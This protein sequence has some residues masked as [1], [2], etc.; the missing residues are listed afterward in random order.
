MRLVVDSL[1]TGDTTVAQSTQHACRI[2]M[3]DLNAEKSATQPGT[4]THA[5]M[6]SISDMNTAVAM[7]I[8]A[9]GGR[10]PSVDD[11][12]RLEK[13]LNSSSATIERVLDPNQ[14]FVEMPNQ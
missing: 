8:T 12:D 2:A 7:A 6:L 11:L 3:V 14:P 9:A 13:K 5:A 4:R 1:Q 10:E